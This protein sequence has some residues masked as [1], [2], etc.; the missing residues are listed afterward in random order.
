[1]HGMLNKNENI[2]YFDCKSWDESFEP[3]YSMIGQCLS[4]KK[5]KWYRTQKQKKLVTEQVF[6]CMY[7]VL[8]IDENK[9]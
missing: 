7:G 6:R 9:N 8:N 2:A 5:W 1:M 3:S 4:K